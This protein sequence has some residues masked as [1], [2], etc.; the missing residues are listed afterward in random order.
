[1]QCATQLGSSQNCFSARAVVYIIMQ[2]VWKLVPHLF[3]E[4]DGS[5]LSAKCAR[6]A[7]ERVLLS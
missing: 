5:A 4:Q 7:G 1:M 6:L 3:S 2:P